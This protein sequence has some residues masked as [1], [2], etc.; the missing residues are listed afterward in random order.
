MAAIQV[1]MRVPEV[2]LARIDAAADEG[3]RSEWILEACRRRLDG[4]PISSNGRFP[5]GEIGEGA[6]KPDMAVLREICDGKG[7]DGGGERYQSDSALPGEFTEPPSNAKLCI[8]CESPMR[9]VKGKW[10]CADP[11]C[12]KY[13]IEQK[14]R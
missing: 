13:G 9:S 10:A 14:P 8:V 6:P 1:N 3:K 12:A 2:L 7:L 11:S 4:I 5:H